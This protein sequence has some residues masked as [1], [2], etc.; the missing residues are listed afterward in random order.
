MIIRTSPS[1]RFLLQRR[2]WDYPVKRYAGTLCLVGGNRNG[3]EGPWETMR[4]ECR[5]ELPAPIA[6]LVLSAAAPFKAYR[7]TVRGGVLPTGPQSSLSEGPRPAYVFHAAVFQAVV[8][9]AAFDRAANA[10]RHASLRMPLLEGSLEVVRPGSGGSG[11]MAWGYGSVLEDFLRA[12][13]P[14]LEQRQSFRDPQ[15]VSTTEALPWPKQPAS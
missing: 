3:I 10:S 13:P 8:G 14:G 9:D 15:G 6:D 11:E 5:E 12:S 2:S 4:R 1:G 7:I